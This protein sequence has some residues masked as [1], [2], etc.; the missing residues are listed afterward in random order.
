MTADV[1][2]TANVCLHRVVW[3][4]TWRRRRRPCRE[5]H[6]WCL[7][8]PIACSIWA[9]VGFASSVLWK[10][11]LNLF[12]TAAYLSNFSLCRISGQI[13]CQPCPPWQTEWVQT[14]MTMFYCD[15]IVKH[16]YLFL[17][18]CP[19][20]PSVQRYFPKEDREASQRHLDRSY[21]CG[22]GRHRRGMRQLPTSKCIDILVWKLLQLRRQ[23]HII[24]QQFHPG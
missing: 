13:C 24:V 19:P 18:V 3:L 12:C 10:T 7:M 9:S 15:D 8:R 4:T 1:R 22:A 5:S 16:L 2:F 17:Y 21:S 11:S 20:S 14:S 6:T 23:I